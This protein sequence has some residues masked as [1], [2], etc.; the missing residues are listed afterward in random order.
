MK[1]RGGCAIAGEWP[2]TM[3][4]SS[5]GFAESVED[6]GEE[7]DGGSGQRSL[8]AL[9]IIE[10]CLGQC[11]LPSD[12]PALSSNVNRDHQVSHFSIP[13]LSA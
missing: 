11:T 12:Y 8:N 1:G 2:R 7:E 5:E 3:G 6:D 13:S 4:T 10:C 9:S